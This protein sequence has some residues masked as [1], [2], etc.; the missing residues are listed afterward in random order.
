MFTG[1][2]PWLKGAA[3]ADTLA[4][5]RARGEGWARLWPMAERLAGLLFR[6][7]AAV[8]E[9]RPTGM[10]EGA[11]ELTAVHEELTGRARPGER[12]VAARLRADELNNRTLSLRELRRAGNEEV[13]RLLHGLWRPIRSTPRRPTTWD[14]ALARRRD[15]RR[16]SDLFGLRRPSQR[17]AAHYPHQLAERGLSC[18]AALAHPACQ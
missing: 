6:R 9:D 7:L 16:G 13:M 11:A 10:T 4:D 18:D 12:P 1:G 3:V 15:H 17:D 2:G 14:A 8:P 5:Y